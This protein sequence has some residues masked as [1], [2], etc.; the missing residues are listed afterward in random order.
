LEKLNG[1]HQMGGVGH[2]TENNIAAE[3]NEMGCETADWM[4]L[5]WSLVKRQILINL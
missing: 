3:L 2:I 4:Q 5:Q 1:I